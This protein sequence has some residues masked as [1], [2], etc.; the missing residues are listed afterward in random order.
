MNLWSEDV[1]SSLI[2]LRLSCI[3]LSKYHKASYFH[4][5]NL[6]KYFRIPTILLSSISSVFNVLLK[7]LIDPNTSSLVCCFISLSVG[8]IGSVELYLNIAKTMETDLHSSTAYGA[9]VSNITKML[10]LDRNHRTIDPIK[11]LEDCNHEFSKLRENSVVRD[12][13]LADRL[14]ELNIIKINTESD[15]LKIINNPNWIRRYQ[16]FLLNIPNSIGG[17]SVRSNSFTATPTPSPRP[18]FSPRPSITRPP[19]NASPQMLQRKQSVDSYN[20]SV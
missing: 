18:S 8:L 4:L 1:E 6:L 10:S 14:L 13:R 16:T 7:E 15:E 2:K 9:I 12:I 11:F 20:T 5:N 3:L 17:G 19:P